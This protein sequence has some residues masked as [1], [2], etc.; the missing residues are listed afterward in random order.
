[1]KEDLLDDVLCVWLYQRRRKGILFLIVK[2]KEIKMHKKLGG[3]FK[4][5]MQGKSAF[6]NGSCFMAKRYVFSTEEKLSTNDDATA[7]I[8]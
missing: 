1:M 3:K 5:L 7:N 8:S 6:I 4:I 2:E